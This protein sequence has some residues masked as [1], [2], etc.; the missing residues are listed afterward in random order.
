M[1]LLH[2][3]MTHPFTIN[4]YEHCFDIVSCCSDMQLLYERHFV[5]VIK[6]ACHTYVMVSVLI[7]PVSELYILCVK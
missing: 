7:M 6:F 5:M 2:F 4:A 1:Y 3:S